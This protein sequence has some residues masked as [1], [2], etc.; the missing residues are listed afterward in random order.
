MHNTLILVIV[1]ILGMTTA[2]FGQAYEL[3]SPADRARIAYREYRYDEAERLFKAALEPKDL[4]DLTRASI[5]RDLG[6]VLLDEERLEEAERV[7]NASLKLFRRFAFPNQTALVMRHLGAVYSIQRR[8][9]EAQKILNDAFKLASVDVA[10]NISVRAEILSKAE[11]FFKQ[12]LELTA[13]AQ[14]AL[15]TQRT[16]LLNNLGAVYCKKEDYAQAEALLTQ[17]LNLTETRF[18]PDFTPLTYTLNTLGILYT[19]MGRYTDAERQYKRA[20]AILEKNGMEFDV[21][22]ARSLR[23]L[24]DTYYKANRM[25]DAESTLARAIE[26]A[27]PSLTTHPDMASILD[28]YSSLLHKLGKSKEAQQVSSEARRARMTMALTFRVTPN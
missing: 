3:D 21:R 17:S 7:Y 1:G 15:D 12:G 27:R 25:S 5:L 22:L 24:S 8:H 18:A 9:K 6:T 23:G 26:V 10:D 19:N 20:I 4:D 14:G 2:L 16:T 11:K 28:A 13:T